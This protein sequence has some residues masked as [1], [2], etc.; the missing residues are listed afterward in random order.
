MTGNDNRQTN[1]LEQDHMSELSKS[2]TAIDIVRYMTQL[3]FASTFFYK[4]T[5]ILALGPGTLGL[6]PG[7]KLGLL[8]FFTVINV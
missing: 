3:Q 1:M 6:G 5:N 7:S 4:S 8:A 2:L